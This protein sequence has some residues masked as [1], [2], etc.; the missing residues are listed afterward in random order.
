VELGDA[1]DWSM[2]AAAKKKTVNLSFA[3]LEAESGFKEDNNAVLAVIHQEDTRGSVSVLLRVFDGLTVS[4]DEINLAARIRASIIEQT[5][6]T[7]DAQIVIGRNLVSLNEKLKPAAFKAFIESHEAFPFGSNMAYR[8]MRIVKE[9]P[10]VQ[11][12]AT[13]PLELT[14]LPA[15]AST[16][17]ELCTLDNAELLEAK[18]NG[19][20][21]PNTLRSDIKRFKERIKEP[22]DSVVAKLRVRDNLLK[23]KHRLERELSEINM[24]LAE[25]G[26]D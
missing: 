15:S 13:P 20:L 18:E 19:L 14:A 21:S 5:E 26:S 6:K 1:G 4:E 25:L 11:Q 24:K 2:S 7:L 12:I 17:Y 3:D 9:L 22:K 16:I 23:R 8:L 10:R